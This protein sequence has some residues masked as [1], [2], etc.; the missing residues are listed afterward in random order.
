MSY[1]PGKFLGDLKE[2]LIMTLINSP[3]MKMMT[4]TTKLMIIMKMFMTTKMMKKTMPTD[5]YEK[6]DHDDV[7]EVN[8]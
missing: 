3:I 6:D 4:T 5:E 8:H 7:D 2:L 1:N